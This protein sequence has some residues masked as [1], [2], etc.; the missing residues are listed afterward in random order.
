MCTK[1]PV[2]EDDE[3]A[4]MNAEAPAVKGEMAVD[5]EEVEDD[6]RLRLPAFLRSNLDIAE[7][8]KTQEASTSTLPVDPNAPNPL[9]KNAQKKAAKLAKMEEG[10]LA[11]RA[12]EKE[13]AKARKHALKA[14]YEAGNM[15]PEEAAEYRE[16]Q[17]ERTDK[18][19][20]KQRGGRVKDKDAWTGGL[21][22]DLAFDE[23]MQP[24]VSEQ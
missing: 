20:A 15:T 21:V 1:A 18:L 2:E 7:E 6:W 22:I 10:K 5:G 23:L 8:P 17:K 14:E 16:R 19:K 12:E 9:S 3:E 11:R 4:A 13:K 24:A